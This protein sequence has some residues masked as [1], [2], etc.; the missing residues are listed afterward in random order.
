MHGRAGPEPQK[1]PNSVYT[2]GSGGVLVNR[3]F[4]PGSDAMRALAIGTSSGQKKM[5]YDS[6]QYSAEMLGSQMS[7]HALAQYSSSG[8]EALTNVP[9]SSA[10]ERPQKESRKKQVRGHLGIK[11]AQKKLFTP[12]SQ[13]T[14]N[15]R[16]DAAA[17]NKHFVQSR[18]RM[19]QMTPLGGITSGLN[20]QAQISQPEC[21][22]STLSVNDRSQRAKLRDLFRQRDMSIEK[23]RVNLPRDGERSGG[24]LPRGSV[25]T[26]T[27]RQQANR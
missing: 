17:K 19:K 7:G 4:R 24:S 10:E 8:G 11:E 15:T 27:L 9:Q 26:E 12:S 23:Y 16:S 25:E 3:L 20:L 5:S 2:S 21:D 1:T 22:A 13:Y 18:L 6:A 14:N